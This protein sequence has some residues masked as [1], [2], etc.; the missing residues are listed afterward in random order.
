M[1]SHQRLETVK[2][3]SHD[4]FL[5]VLIIVVVQPKPEPD[6]F[7]CF[8]LIH[9]WNL[10]V[11]VFLILMSSSSVHPPCSSHADSW[12]KRYFEWKSRYRTCLKKVLSLSPSSDA[13]S[14]ASCDLLCCLTCSMWKWC[15]HLAP[16]FKSCACTFLNS[17]KWSSL[18]YHFFHLCQCIPFT[19]HFC[20]L[21]GQFIFS[22]S[23]LLRDLNPGD[24]L[25]KQ[26]L[27]IK[28]TL[29]R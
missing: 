19:V 13:P 4:Y 15:P 7:L 2:Y 29:A 5:L 20:F 16:S 22:L 3:F 10:H 6:Y 9:Q 18:S 25:V 21:L 8:L 27:K 17:T 28:K 14:N 23:K 24:L 26:F 12:C 1:F 11:C